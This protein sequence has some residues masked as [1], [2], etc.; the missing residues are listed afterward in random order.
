MSEIFSDKK[1][2][3]SYERKG[4]LGDGNI[5]S[6][7]IN[8][9]MRAILIDW[10]VEIR[11]SLK[12]NI[13]TLCLT[14]NI[15]DAY[16][17][18]D[19]NIKKINFQL[20]G[21]CSMLLASKYEEIYHPAISDF[22]YLADGAYTEDQI[23]QQENLIF[24]TL[25]CNIIYPKE[26]NYQ[27]DISVSSEYT[28]LNHNMCKYLIV[29][30]YYEYN[31]FLP[32]VVVTSITQIISKVYNIP[33]INYFNVPNSVIKDCSNILI[34]LIQ[35]LS[36]STL[37][38]YKH[39]FASR[40]MKNF[41]ELCDIIASIKLSKKDNIGLD[42]KYQKTKY[43]KP[44]LKLKLISKDDI[45]KGNKL[46][47][48]TFGEVYKA[49]Y[50]KINY[51]YKKTK[52]YLEEGLVVSFI[53]ETSIMLSLNHE[54]ILSIE[55]ITDN[56]KGFLVDL[57]ISDLKK[58]VGENIINDDVQLNI[59]YQLL[60]ALTYI[61]RVGCLHRDIKPQNIIVFNGEDNTFVFKIADFGSARGPQIALRD[62][63][64]TN[65]ISTIYYRAPEILLGITQY[66]D[67]VD[68]WS[69]LCTLYESATNQVLFDGDSNIDQLFKIFRILGTPNENS[70]EGI[71]SYAYN[72]SNFPQFKRLPNFFN[73]NNKLSALSKEIFNLGFIL[74]PKK[75]LRSYELLTIVEKYI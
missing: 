59:S 62:N 32:S 68:V 55:F 42:T 45:K 74:D 13:D 2:L 28:E 8:I 64:F 39:S 17:C 53:R 50:E 63:S 66:N 6:V 40:D 58:W 31:P 33:Y 25:G 72:Q 22:A 49:K 27:R 29:L 43:F 7:K 18:R 51:A 5:L 37:E 47:E 21:I 75:R 20:I 16:I 9:K 3:L 73:H 70:W 26:I 19:S 46:G 56:L 11:K 35:R 41:S 57:G 15:I 14:I 69:M 71:S 60:S 48:G 12:L 23:I 1:S 34:N 44:L 4:M 52:N 36:K 24:I 61:H 67:V 38:N 65:V 10:L 30:S 54:N